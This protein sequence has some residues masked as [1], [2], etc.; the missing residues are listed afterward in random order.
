MNENN[1]DND[2][3]R[4]KLLAMILGLPWLEFAGNVWKIARKI[5][6]GLSNEGI[7][8]VLEYECTLELKD[9]EGKQAKIHKRKKIRYIQ[10][11]ITTYLDEAWGTNGEI[12]L[13]YQCSPG[14]PVDEYRLGHKTYKLI[15]LR[16]FRN[17]GDVDEF[18]IIWN[19]R[20]GFLLPTGFWGTAINQRMKKLR[21]KIIFPKNRPPLQFAVTESNLKRTRAL[22]KEAQQKLPDGRQMVVWENDKPRLY[23]DYILSWEW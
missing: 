11:Y 20:N 18:N 21:V 5:I 17:K 7:Y 8:E 23:E 14:I 4:L 15:S 2:S 12:L 19:M 3:L 13:D 22:G 6:R 1:Q 16:E 9:K 10:D